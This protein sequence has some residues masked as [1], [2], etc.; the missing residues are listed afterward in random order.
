MG[1]RATTTA[2]T[3]MTAKCLVAMPQALHEALKARAR[4]IDRSNSAVIRRLVKAFVEMKPGDVLCVHS[5]SDNTFTA[6]KGL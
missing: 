1:K 2:S 6:V 3:A 5:P 4:D